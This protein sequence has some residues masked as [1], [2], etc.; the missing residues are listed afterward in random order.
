MADPNPGLQFDHAEFEGNAPATAACTS[1]QKPLADTY[2][3]VGGLVTCESCKRKIEWDWNQSSDFGARV[4]RLLRATLYGTLAGAAG[5]G[6]YYLVLALTGWQVGLISILVGLMVGGAVRA[7][8]RR[9][10]GWLYQGLAMF[11][12]YTAIVFSYVPLIIKEA[13]ANQGLSELQESGPIAIVIMSIVAIP[14]L[15]V[16]PFLMVA[17]DLGSLISVLIIAFGVYEAWKMNKK[18]QLQVTGPYS[19]AARAAEPAPA[20]IQP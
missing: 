6:L 14:F 3:E 18:E 15:Y 4:G 13:Q 20:P 11:I 10:G 12:T 5:C 17:E 16:L 2:Y 1:C 7:G 19:L 8:A 9:R